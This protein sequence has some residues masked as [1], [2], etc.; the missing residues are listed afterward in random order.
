MTKIVRL[1]SSFLIKSTAFY[2]KSF[3]QIK[4]QPRVAASAS[5]TGAG[6][7]HPVRNLRGRALLQSPEMEHS[8]C[9]PGSFH[10]D[11]IDEHSVA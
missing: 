8:P 1:L 11:S 6:I 4:P 7:P 3:K 10:T 2:F 9:G 5:L